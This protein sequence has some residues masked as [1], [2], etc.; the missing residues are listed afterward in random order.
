MTHPTTRRRL[1]RATTLTWLALVLLSLASVL[2]ASQSQPGGHR[3]VLTAAVA[4]IAWV[5]AQLLIR[6][7]LQARLAGPR[8]HRIVQLFAALAPLILL[9]SAVREAWPAA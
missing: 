5:K 2:V 1:P 3:L 6:H 7:Y 8:L 9:V 4:T